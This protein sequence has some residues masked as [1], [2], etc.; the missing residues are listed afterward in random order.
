MVVVAPCA[1]FLRYILRGS[2]RRKKVLFNQILVLFLTYFTYMSYHAAKR[3]FSVV[4]ATLSPDC[5]VT[6]VNNTCF[7]WKPFD[8][9]Q[10]AKDLFG[11]LDCSFLI[12]YALAMYVSG[13]IAEHS[14]LRIYLSFGMILTGLL[15]S[16]LGFAY[17][18][19][20]HNLTYFFI[21]L[22]LTGVT[23]ST[24]WPCMVECV[25]MWFPKGKRGVIMGIWNTHTSVGNMAGSALAGIFAANAWGLSFIIPGIMIGTFGILNFLFLIPDP[26][27]IGLAIEKPETKALHGPGYK[28]LTS[29]TEDDDLK[30]SASVVSGLGDTIEPQI[31]DGIGICSA[32]KIPGVIEYSTCLF[33]AKLVSYTFLFWLPYYIKSTPIGGSHLTVTQSADLAT[34]FDVGG[35]FGGIAAGILV[36]YSRRPGMVN[37]GM[38]ILSA[39]SL[40]LFKFYGNTSYTAFI[41]YMMVSGFLVN[42]PYALIT[43]AVSASLGSHQSLQG[44]TKAMA[45]VT[46]IIDGTGSLGAALGPLLAGLVS[47]SRNSWDDVFYMLIGCDLA[48]AVLLSRQVLKECRRTCI[49]CNTPNTTD[50]SLNHND[51][52]EALLKDGV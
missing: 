45:V 3:P 11:L 46:A 41:S 2:S 50:A 18:L 43:T 23:Q 15:T 9:R 12:T 7:P 27:H 31:S 6:K 20:V 44:N 24:G 21:F 48:A 39:P 26:A 25:G 52:T 40:F 42:G 14:N 49:S 36:D 35:A 22:I 37:V 16:A 47:S 29:S 5:N 34:L 30:S 1:P 10:K 17:Y 33:F 4:K 8:N 28:G 19:Q 38:L 13:Y 51:E 32:L